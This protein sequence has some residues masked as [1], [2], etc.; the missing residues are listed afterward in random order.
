VYPGDL[1]RPGRPW[2]GRTDHNCFGC[3][4]GNP[5]GL[6]LAFEPYA[7]DGVRTRFTLNRQYESYPG[8]VHG[9]IVS[10][11]CDETMGNLIVARRGHPGLTVSMRQRFIAPVATG[12]PYVCVA[13]FSGEQSERLYRTSAEVLDS[14]GAVCATATAT[15]T[16]L[17]AIRQ[18]NGP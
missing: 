7:D 11:I 18:R 16:P 1:A 13:R 15:Y 6:H 5:V 12:R 17:P 8:I 9:G 3:S 14:R 4:P 2:A 10:V